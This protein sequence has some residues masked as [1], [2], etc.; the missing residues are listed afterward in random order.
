MSYALR[1]Q[2]NEI[3]ALTG[4]PNIEG[5][6][7]LSFSDPEVLDFLTG[8]RIHGIQDNRFSQLLADDLRSIRIVEDLIDLL[9]AKGIILFSELPERTQ[10]KL[11]EKK[12]RRAEVSRSNEIIVD[13]SISFFEA[14]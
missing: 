11:L 6:Q 4:T 14:E 8:T 9:I 2:N 7:E 13:D 12:A 5:D 10:R 1:N 3:V